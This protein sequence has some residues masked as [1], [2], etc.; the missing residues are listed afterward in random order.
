MVQWIQYFVVIP[1]CVP[2][3]L[4][5]FS[6]GNFKGWKCDGNCGKQISL[7]QLC[8]AQMGWSWYPMKGHLCEL[9][10][11]LITDVKQE[12]YRPKSVLRQFSWPVTKFYLKD[13]WAIS[14]NF[15]NLPERC[16]G[17]FRKFWKFGWVELAQHNQGGGGGNSITQPRQKWNSF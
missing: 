8:Q 1:F 5:P 15:E 2:Q 11:C 4:N 7:C 13:V 6:K 16:L 9:S 12:G 14:E 3:Q 10:S 17:H